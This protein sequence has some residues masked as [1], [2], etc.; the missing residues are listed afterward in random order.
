MILNSILFYL[1]TNTQLVDSQCG[2]SS[3][4]FTSL[5]TF[6]DVVL[7]AGDNE[8]TILSVGMGVKNYGAHLERSRAGIVGDVLING[9]VVEGWTHSVGLEGADGGERVD[10]TADESIFSW[11][12]VKF[13]TPA[14]D[15][16]AGLAVDMTSMG[17]G[18][19]SVNGVML[20]RYWS[21]VGEIEDDCKPCDLATY[22]GAYY[23][24]ICRSGCGEPSQSYYK[25]PVSWLSD[26]GDENVI[27]IFEES[28]GDVGGVG[29]VKMTME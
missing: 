11:Y 16:A 10:A 3:N 23:N 14:L 20:G 17:K 28:G 13:T 1:F 2:G 7:A 22:S 25:L 18:M 9:F 29:L 5:V 21:I 19:V 24:Q 26:E 6:K 15:A 12:E 4:L 8:V 27:V